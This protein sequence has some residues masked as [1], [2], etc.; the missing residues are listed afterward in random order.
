MLEFQ[1]KNHT[2]IS[3]EN[4]LKYLLLIATLVSV[5]TTFAILFAILFESKN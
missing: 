5:F 3:K 4:I 2:K 1:T